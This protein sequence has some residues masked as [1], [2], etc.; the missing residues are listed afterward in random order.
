M[1]TPTRSRRGQRGITTAEVLVG[2]ALTLMLMTAM[3][4]T[5]QV[6]TRSFATQSAYSQSQNVTRT[7]ID[8]MTREMRMIAYDP[9]GLALPVTAGSCP[10]V[11][12]GILDAR[13]DRVQ[14]RQDLSGDGD[15]ADASETITYSLSDGA[16]WRQDGNDASILLVD[17]VTAD[18]LE[19]RYFDGVNPPNELV[20]SGTPAV[21]SQNQ[22]NCVA[23]IMVTARAEIPNPDP[24]VDEPLHSVARSEIAIRNLSLQNF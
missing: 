6:Q 19:L 16:I 20:P 9:T 4:S 8:L 14:F 15:V 3:F 18:G 12:L 11:K 23:K 10:G 17:G 2:A 5:F 7:M 24:R 21:L 22:R 1:R 13:T